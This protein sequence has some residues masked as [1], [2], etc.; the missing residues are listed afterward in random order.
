[1][2]EATDRGRG[3]PTA[4]ATIR[5]ALHGSSQDFTEGPIGRAVVL[6][7]IPMVLEMSMESLFAVTDMFFVSKLGPDAVASV[8][9]SESML[10]I[11]YALAMGLSISVTAVVSRRIGEKDPEGAAHGAA[12]SLLLGVAICNSS[13]RSWCRPGAEA[14]R[15]DGRFAGCDPRGIGLHSRGSSAGK[16]AS[17]SSSCSTP[18]SAAPGDPCDRDASPVDLEWDQHRP[19]SAADLRGR[20]VP[21][22]SALRARQSQ[23]RSG[24]ATGALLALRAMIPRPGDDSA[25]VAALRA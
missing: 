12:Q 5:E 9:L 10:S 4:W 15:R 23:R 3:S 7:A 22:S 21:R 6:L 11:V 13:R 8:G 25:S 16:P 1:M 14:S 20:P 2:N 17:S 19:E 24:R 18:P